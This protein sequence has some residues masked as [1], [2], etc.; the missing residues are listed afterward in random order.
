MHLI[1]SAPTVPSAKAVAPAS[2][3]GDSDP[4][5]SLHLRLCAAQMRLFFALWAFSVS[6]TALAVHGAAAPSAR[7]RSAVPY[8][9]RVK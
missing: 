2:G 7:R 8:L 4:L 6:T 3:E 9:R 1:F 5:A